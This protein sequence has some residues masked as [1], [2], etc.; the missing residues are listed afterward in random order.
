[1][2]LGVYRPYMYVGYARSGQDAEVFA[3]YGEKN[4]KRLTEI[5]KSV[6]PRGVF[7]STGLWRGHMKII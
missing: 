3:G 1:M 5:Q 6:D 2:G 7:T 4:L